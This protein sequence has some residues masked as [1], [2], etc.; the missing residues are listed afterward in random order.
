MLARGL[1]SSVELRTT[2]TGI[3]CGWWPNRW[4]LRGF[5]LQRHLSVIRRH[6]MRQQQPAQRR[7]RRDTDS[8]RWVGALLLVDCDTK[9]GLARCG[10]HASPTKGVKGRFLACNW[11]ARLASSGELLS[12][13]A[14]A[15]G[16]PGCSGKGHARC[17]EQ[18]GKPGPLGS[19][20]RP[21]AA[22]ARFPGSAQMENYEKG[23][24]ELQVCLQPRQA[25]T[26]RASRADTSAGET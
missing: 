12:S 17:G 26:M 9:L 7:S 15:P 21:S 23:A 4:R 11:L 2:G 14:S 25:W 13:L 19:S 24:S 18:P 6:G 8:A 1:P 20:S 10:R 3:V 22:A 16:A 5:C